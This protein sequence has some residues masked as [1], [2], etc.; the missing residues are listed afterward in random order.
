MRYK[1]DV[2]QAIQ[3]QFSVPVHSLD[4]VLAQ[5]RTLLE[6]CRIGILNSHQPLPGKVE[7]VGVEAVVGAESVEQQ[8]LEAAEILQDVLAARALREGL[9]DL[10]FE[11]LRMLECQNEL[12]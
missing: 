9:V 4:K 2:H 11:S 1:L 3:L 5:S 8:S 12:E 7:A 10:I 6:E